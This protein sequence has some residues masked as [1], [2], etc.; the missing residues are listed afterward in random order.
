MLVVVDVELVEHAE[1][2]TLVGTNLVIRQVDDKA[3]Q[4]RDPLHGLDSDNLRDTHGVSDS[5][6]VGVNPS[7]ILVLDPAQ[8][9]ENRLGGVECWLTRTLVEMPAGVD[10]LDHGVSTDVVLSNLK[11]MGKELMIRSDRTD[12]LGVDIVRGLDIAVV[13]KQNC[14]SNFLMEH[15]QHLGLDPSH[16]VEGGDVQH[17]VPV[18][19]LA[20]IHRGRTGGAVLQL[21]ELVLLHCA[22]DI[23]LSS[24]FI[25]G[26]VCVYRTNPSKRSTGDAI[27]HAID[28]LCPTLNELRLV[29]EVLSLRE[30]KVDVGDTELVRVE[31]H[32]FLERAHLLG[33]FEHIGHVRVRQNRPT[34]TRG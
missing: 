25:L 4:V 9:T 13:T 28:P 7:T 23:T 31:Q 15:Q 12:V 8:L 22:L 1:L 30:Q 29:L 21:E 26:D 34:T 6:V 24:G 27:H 16:G 18:H 10:E 14:R 3:N 11:T 32:G 33:I 5:L 20:L 19:L 2:T 17:V